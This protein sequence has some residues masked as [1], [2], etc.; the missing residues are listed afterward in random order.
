M[1]NRFLDLGNGEKVIP[2]VCTVSMLK[3]TLQESERDWWCGT[4]QDNFFP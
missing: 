3:Q 2:G 4:S 1:R